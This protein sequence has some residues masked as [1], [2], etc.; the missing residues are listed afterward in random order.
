MCV[1]CRNSVADTGVLH[2]LFLSTLRQGLSLSL[3]QAAS[4]SDS[5]ITNPYSHHGYQCTRPH[6]A[7]YMGSKDLNSV[8]HI[9]AAIEFLP[10]EPSP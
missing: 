4:P 3:Q 2:S 6:L 10:A 5:L 8:P 1:L 9:C 7:F